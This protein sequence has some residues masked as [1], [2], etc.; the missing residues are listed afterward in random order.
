MKWSVVLAV[1]VL[2]GM[3]AGQQHV[4]AGDAVDALQEG[5]EIVRGMAEAGIPTTRVSDLYR[6][7]NA[8]FVGQNASADPDYSKVTA[9]VER[10]RGIEETAFRVHDELGLLN[11]TVREL[12]AEGLNTSDVEDHYRAARIAFRGERFETAAEEVDA[13]REAVSNARAVSTRVQA[14]SEAARGDIASFVDRNRWTLLGGLLLLAVVT[15]GGYR[16]LHAYRLLKRKE[17]LEHRKAVL[18]DLIAESQQAYFEEGEIA[19]ETYRT[20]MDRY[21]EMVRD[22]NRQIPVIE[23]ELAEGRTVVQWVGG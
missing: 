11:E 9:I 22:I 2:A 19:E 12:R 7:A 1:V 8:T 14:F 10:M 20:R 23:E 21:G 3:A 15:V 16:E 17:R 4:T 18:E 6:R 5:R 13:T